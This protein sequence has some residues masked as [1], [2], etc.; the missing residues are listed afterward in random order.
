MKKGYK[1]IILFLILM[2]ALASGLSYLSL[3]HVTKTKNSKDV[4][5]MS[6]ALVNEDEGATFNNDDLSFGKA[7]V[8]SLDKN[9]EHDWYVVSRGVAENGLEQNTYDMMIVIPNDFSEKALSISS[10]SPEHVVLNYK[11][12]AS[13]NEDFQAE[14]E[15][16]ASSVLN[17]FNRRIIDV[18]F[19]SVIGNLQEAQDNINEV[20]EEEAL[21]TNTYNNAIHSPLAN[22]TDRFRNVKNSTEVSKDS[23]SGFEETLDTFDDQLNQDAEMSQDYLSSMDETSNLLESNSVLSMN[24]LDQLYQL[25]DG[26]TS[27]D[28]DEQLEKLL[29]ANNMIN[30][31]FQ[32]SEDD[33]ATIVSNTVALKTY[34]ESSLKDVEK[35]H[36][37]VNEKLNSDLRSKVEDR[38]T[39]VFDDAF[40]GNLINLDALF[41]ESDEN[42]RLRMNEQ[43]DNLPTLSEEDIVDLGLSYETTTELKNVLA[44][45][46]KYTKEFGY[47]PEQTGEATQL[48]QEINQL[49][50]HLTRKGVTATDSVMLPKTNSEGKGQLFKLNIPDEYELQYVS[51]K[52]PNEEEAK[53][54]TNLIDNHNQVVLPGFGE[55]KFTV[56]V[57]LKLK[58][59]KSLINILQPVTWSWDLE[60]TDSGEVDTPE[61]AAVELP[62][63]PLTAS[64]STDKSADTSDDSKRE[65]DAE[66][67]TAEQTEK[68]INER[69]ENKQTNKE[70]DESNSE[71][72]KITDQKNETEKPE[73]AQD[74]KQDDSDTPEQVEIVDHHIHHEVMSPEIDEGTENLVNAVF[75]TISPYQKLL[76]LYEMYFGFDLK[77]SKDNCSN[78]HET[79]SE[80]TS[81]KEMATDSSLYT[82]FNENN[83][84]KL[85]AKQVADDV[86]DEIRQPL[87][88][89]QKQIGTFQ[90]HVKQANQDADQLVDQV[91]E[92]KEQAAVLNESLARTLANVAKWREKSLNLVDQQT[93]IQANNDE[94]KTAI[95]TLGNAFQ[96]LLA[97]SQSLADQAQSNLNAAEHVYKTFDR[98]DDQASSIQD[99]GTTL[100]SKAEELSTNMTNN[101]L[102]DQEFAENF[103]DVLANSRIGDR[104]NEDLYDFLSNPVQTKNNGTIAAGDK[105]TPY[106]VVLVC[107]II[108][109]F[110]AY[111]ISMSNQRQ[112]AGDQFETEKSL[113][114]KNT[115]ITSI[116]GGIGVAEGIIIGL[117]SGY[118]LEVSGG[119][120][121]KWVGLITL[122]MIVMLLVATYLLRQ[123]KMI[124]MFILLAVLS[125][126]LFLTRALGSGFVGLETVRMYS[127]LQYV[128]TLVS[129]TVQGQ[130]GY[131]TAMFILA[132]LALIGVIA[133]LLVLHRSTRKGEEDD[134]SDAKAN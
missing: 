122:V 77:C 70:S 62:N 49:R 71:K 75:N 44:V 29:F 4:Q 102:E 133:N 78:I 16:T 127:P 1:G 96:P 126:Y 69:V 132:G 76:S 28:V 18:Y 73:N 19:A 129:K 20:V 45:T 10:E 113:M 33:A 117:L 2:I 97:S 56:K 88:R 22:Y 121:V 100:V 8:K 91:V 5:T 109:L 124:G 38:L 35:A 54:Y 90:Q 65:T 66:E 87:E 72:Q 58:S 123:L 114:G 48:T 86:T 32:R 84:G 40:N 31:Q 116:T 93:E 94:E 11:I 39:T 50:E 79:L 128:E 107:F 15:K 104:Q 6:V 119:E 112:L 41:E 61:Y 106:F 92:T 24:F 64:M 7:F 83:I 99:S 63:T 110:T 67:Q 21:Y 85:L 74:A 60:P 37:N 108:A 98:I 120:L 59:D 131:G 17:D 103:A 95:M 36:E 80:D 13:G 14:A 34:L 134:E 12:N 57:T 115:L 105:F 118:F 125:L 55:G 68:Q 3:D 52:L 43:I 130:A 25:E 51:L 53:N 30:Q 111:V 27:E 46:D 42:S 81:L 89:L 82:L 23:F 47:T 26:L 101:L 9:N